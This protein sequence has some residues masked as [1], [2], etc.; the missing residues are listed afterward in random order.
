MKRRVKKSRENRFVLYPLQDGETS[1]LDL[2]S[3]S[4]KAKSKK[5]LLLICKLLFPEFSKMEKESKHY[6][7]A[8][9]SFLAHR[10]IEFQFDYRSFVIVHYFWIIDHLFAPAKYASEMSDL[11]SILYQSQ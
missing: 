7:K 6:Y 10:I 3:K 11:G 8:L 2:H 1:S 5:D 4:I 9:S